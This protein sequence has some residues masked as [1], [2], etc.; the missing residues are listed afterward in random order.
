M[1][2]TISKLPI[3]SGIVRL[4]NV[5]NEERPKGMTNHVQCLIGFLG[6]SQIF[7][8]FINTIHQNHNVLRT[9]DLIRKIKSKRISKG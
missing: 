1:Y 5:Q 4:P 8:H 3:I 6:D 2:P 9:K 7:K